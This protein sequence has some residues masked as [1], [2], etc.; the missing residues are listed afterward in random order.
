LL[1]AYSL[2]TS[3]EEACEILYY[4]R[5]WERGQSRG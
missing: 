1:K 4:E 2:M 3:L 5:L